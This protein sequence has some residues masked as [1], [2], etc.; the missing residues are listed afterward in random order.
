MDHVKKVVEIQKQ[1]PHDFIYWVKQVLEVGTQHLVP[2]DTIQLNFLQLNDVDIHFALFVLILVGIL[3]I[4][5]VLKMM[6]RCCCGKKSNK[7][8][9]E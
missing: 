2:S 7:K 4:G 6:L 1:D 9:K 8:K 5:F 3:T